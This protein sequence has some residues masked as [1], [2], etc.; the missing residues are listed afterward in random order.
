MGR[1][2]QEGEGIKG[3]YSSRSYQG[4]KALREAEKREAKEVAKSVKAL[5]KV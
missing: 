5:E 2:R 3:G 4:V 1:E